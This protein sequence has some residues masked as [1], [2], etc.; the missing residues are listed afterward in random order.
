MSCEIALIVLHYLHR[1]QEICASI[2]TVGHISMLLSFR[3]LIH[4]E[5]YPGLSPILAK[6][7][8]IME[9]S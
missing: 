1:V 6:S 4:R 5:P 3:L 8:A 7:Q 9:P 2:L